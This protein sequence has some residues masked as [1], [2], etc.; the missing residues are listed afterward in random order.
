MT[1]NIVVENGFW[2]EEISKFKLVF[3]NKNLLVIPSDNSLFHSHLYE[4]LSDKENFNLEHFT[5]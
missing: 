5:I 3:L 1:F 4:Y 2:Y